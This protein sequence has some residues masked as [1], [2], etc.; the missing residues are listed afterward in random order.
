MPP[1]PRFNVIVT[2]PPY[3]LAMEF[4]KQAFKWRASEQ[5]LVVILLRLNVL[6]SQKRAAWLREHAPSVYVSPRR[7]TFTWRGTDSCEHAW[8]IWGGA[9]KVRILKTAAN[10][11]G[12]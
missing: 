1:V 9:P 11:V 3:K 7:P 6:G 4:V 12:I 2:N 5:S 10:H 8:F